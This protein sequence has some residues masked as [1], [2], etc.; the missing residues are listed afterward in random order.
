MR[1]SLLDT[2]VV[3]ILFKPDHSLFGE[4]SRLVDGAHLCIS[5]MSRAELLLWPLQ[6]SW[7]HSRR[8]HLLRHV[9]RCTTIFPD[10]DTCVQWSEISSQS[11]ATGRGISTSDAW[12]A[13]TA[14]QWKLPL[15]TTYRRDF[16]HVDGLTVVAVV[17]RVVRHIKRKGRAQPHYLC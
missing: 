9:D 10:H 5:F 4:C 17:Y 2:T 6:N 15:I 3:S 1:V 16:E 11:R 8:D 14:R 12:I 7:G 13:A